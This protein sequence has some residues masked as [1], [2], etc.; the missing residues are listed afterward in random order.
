MALEQEDCDVLIVGAGPVGLLH[1]CGLGVRRIRTI[2]V[3]QREGPLAHP[4]A[5]THNARSMLDGRWGRVIQACFIVGCDARRSWC[6][7]ISA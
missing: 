1:A 6:A 4:K 5:N 3:E 7:G 2:V